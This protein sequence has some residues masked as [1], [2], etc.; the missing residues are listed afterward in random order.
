M[1]RTETVPSRLSSE[2]SFRTDLQQISFNPEGKST[3][4]FRRARNRRRWSGRAVSAPF[5]SSPLYRG[6]LGRGL[7]FHFGRHP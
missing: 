5:F 1:D 6:F 7:C 4:R 3:A 2:S